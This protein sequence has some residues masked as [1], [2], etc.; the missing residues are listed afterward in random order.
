[1][2]P[3]WWEANRFSQE[4]KKALLRCLIDKVVVHR[5]AP[6]TV[7]CRV[8]WKGGE[9]TEAR[10][11]VTVGALALLSGHEEMEE[12]IH[13]LARQGIPDEEIA[14]RLTEQGYRSPKDRAVLPSTVQILR[15]RHRL[16]RDRH[17]SHPRRIA[18]FL[19]V[20]QLAS[21]LKIPRHWIYDRIH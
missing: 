19:T 8:V 17:Q 10:L 18:G 11:A 6:D 2:I 12:V 13:Q 16:F 7:H 15:L 9:T 5:S 4:Q 3:E 14:R 1:K 20:P 21:K